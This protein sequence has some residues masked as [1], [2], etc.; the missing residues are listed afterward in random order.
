MLN[1]N[2]DVGVAGAP[3]VPI[4]PSD[5]D[6]VV[7]IAMIA[8]S[9]IILSFGGLIVRNIEEADPWQINFY[10]A[11]GLSVA[12]AV[13]LAVN[14]RGEAV[15]RIRRSGL[16]GVIAGG[17]LAAAGMSYIQA[18]THTTVANTMFTLA[19]IPFITAA[20]AWLFLQERLRLATVVSMA[21]AFIGIMLMVVDGFGL[22][23]TYGNLM[24]LATA[25]FFSIFAI[26]VRKNRNIDMLPALLI[27]GIAIMLTTLSVRYGQLSIGWHDLMLCIVWGGLMSGFANWMFIAASRHLAAAE[28]T[29]FML[30][31]FALA[32]IWVWLFLSEGPT[33]WSLIGGLVVITSV[34]GRT[35]LELHR[36]GHR[37]K[38]GRPSPG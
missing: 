23:A 33:R 20:M 38:R 15:D 25:L 17:S 9:S 29:L 3:A 24:A 22:G 11:S 27:S 32:P 6:R 31:E 14:Y 26:I 8:V 10:R 37:L 35:L 4:K 1:Q 2:S 19:A 18:I 7:A 13:V 21:M 16:A 12:I 30:L 36:D 34:C 5:R 28:L